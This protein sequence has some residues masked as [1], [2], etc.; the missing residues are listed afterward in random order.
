HLIPGVIERRC[1]PGTPVA[2]VTVSYAV[3]TVDK[4]LQKVGLT[5]PRLY[6]PRAQT[7]GDWATSHRA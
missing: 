5:L 7:D 1:G 6:A 4:L 3:R 2:P